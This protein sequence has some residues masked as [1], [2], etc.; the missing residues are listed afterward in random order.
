MIPLRYN[1]RNLFVRWKTTALTSL[2]FV[3]VVGLL[4][5]MLA[6]VEG[7]NALS[8]KTGPEGNVILL[9]DGA[10]DELF[11][12]IAVNQENLSALWL[13]PEVL[14]EQGKPL[15]SKEVYSIATQEIPPAEEGGRKTYRFL[16]V[17]GVEDPAR[18]GRVHGLHLHAGGR[19]F[20]ETGTECVMGEGIA[21]ALGKKLG[22]VF[23]PRP[24]LA[25]KIVGIL[26]SRGTPFDSEIWA[27]LADI[28]RYFGKDNEQTGQ[29]FYTSIVVATKDSATAEKFAREI[30]D[31]VRDIRIHAQPE[32]KYYASLS[33]SNQMFE[34]VALFIAVVMAIGGMFGLMNTMF[35]A[36]SQ[37]IKDIGVLRILGY[38][39]WQILYS[40]LLESLLLAG[41]GGV[42]GIACGYLVHGVEQ[43]SYVSSGQGGGKTVVFTLIVN[44]T[45][46]LWAVSF[47][48]A[49]GII[50]GILPAWAAMRL[51]PLDAV[52]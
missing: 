30:Q 14:T 37:R 44:Q 10:T 48:V 24:D 52:R 19:W 51:R 28:G 13:Q 32:R 4:V 43:T 15:V 1:V 31:R 46:V 20:D 3:L 35:A 34:G 12:E 40:F 50:G 29:R 41:I 22:D 23:Q 17:R 16:Q 2:G 39:H 7:L 18:S 33:K 36:V 5:V 8:Q 42:A 25:W 38:T 26:D 27:K 45:V 9:R 11:S 6:F 49:M 21:R 47:T